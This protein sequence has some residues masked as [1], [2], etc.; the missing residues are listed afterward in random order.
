MR[1]ILGKRFFN[2]PTLLVARELLGKFL[3]RRIYGREVALMI[4]ETEG[5]D[6]MKDKACHAWRGQ[7]PRNTPMFGHP[8]HAYVY[9]TYGMHFMLNLVTREKGYPAA[10]LIRGGVLARA[11]EGNYSGILKNSRI[12]G[13]GRLT[14]VLTIDKRLNAEPLSKASGLWVEDRGITFSDKKIVR[15]PRIGVDGA[16]PYWAGRRYRFVI[17]GNKKRRGRRES[18]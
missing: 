5:Y 4:T 16:G 12:D 15:T 17:K 6:G 2:R 13:P 18:D 14:K 9:F 3:V 11:G 1:R 8:G 10:V 7:T